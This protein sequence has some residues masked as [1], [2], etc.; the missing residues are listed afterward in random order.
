MTGLRTPEPRPDSGTGNDNVAGV[1][2]PRKEVLEGAAERFH[3]FSDTEQPNFSRT[4]FLAEPQP[5]RGRIETDTVVRHVYAHPAI[6]LL[7]H[8]SRL[9]RAGILGRIDQELAD[10]S[11]GS[12]AW[13][14]GM[15]ISMSGTRTVTRRSCRSM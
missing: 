2:F 3:A 5:P 9:R 15:E 12:T 7:E 6:H 10:G 14:S 8:D 4:R 11:N 13:S 1:P